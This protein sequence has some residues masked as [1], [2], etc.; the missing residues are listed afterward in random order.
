[1]KEF[2]VTGDIAPKE[3]EAAEIFLARRREI[4]DMSLLPETLREKVSR[5]E[6]KK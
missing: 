1:M 2:K 4:T 5:V 6:R 3:R